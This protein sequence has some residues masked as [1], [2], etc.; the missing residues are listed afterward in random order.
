MSSNVHINIKPASSTDLHTLVTLIEHLGYSATA[1]DIMSRLLL[2]REAGGEV[3]VAFYKG[4]PAGCVQAHK[5]TR[6]AEGTQGEVVSL[7]V[8]DTYQRKGVG[9]QLVQR[10]ETWFRTEKCTSI[11]VRVNSLREEAE[12]FYRSIGYRRLKTQNIFIKQIS[13][14]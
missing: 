14:N 13:K 8:L 10:V 1:N 4:E 2:I 12:H 6:L 3:F 9:K 5:E 7:S 11:K